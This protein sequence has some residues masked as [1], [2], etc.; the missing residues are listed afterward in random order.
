[1]YILVFLDELPEYH[2][3]ENRKTRWLEDERRNGGNNGV[4][5][6]IRVTS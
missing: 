1:M 3:I 6:G 2:I 4:S 5:K